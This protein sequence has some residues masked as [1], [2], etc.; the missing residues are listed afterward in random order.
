MKMKAPKK[1]RTIVTNF[2][3]K[4]WSLRRWQIFKVDTLKLTLFGTDQ[5]E[6]G[7]WGSSSMLSIDLIRKLNG[8]PYNFALKPLPYSMMSPGK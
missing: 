8:V 4:T 5:V 1:T 7:I 2:A 6:Y 3:L